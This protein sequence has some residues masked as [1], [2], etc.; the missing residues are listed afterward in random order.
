V[1]LLL[2]KYKYIKKERK[3]EKDRGGCRIPK[4]GEGWLAATPGH[5]W[6]GSQGTLEVW[7]TL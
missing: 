6:G 5:L 4:G 2:K 7:A 3:K 1:L